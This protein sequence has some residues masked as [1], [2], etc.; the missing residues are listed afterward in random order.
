MYIYK[1]GVV[2]GGTMGAQ[3]AQVVTFGGLPVV[4]ADIDEAAAQ[5]GVQT[6][7]SIYQAR[8]DKGKMSAE[9]LEEKMLLVSAAGNLKALADVD[10]VI[11]PT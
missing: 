6:V 11:E 4:I 1:V 3:I 8:V 7:R 2:G 10:L 9:Q 5:R